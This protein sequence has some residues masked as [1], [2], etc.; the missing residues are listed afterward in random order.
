MVA[1]HNRAR[2]ESAVASFM[3]FLIANL[4]WSMPGFGQFKVVHIMRNI[5]L[6]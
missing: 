1:D 6:L 5:K 2:Y 4:G 3:V